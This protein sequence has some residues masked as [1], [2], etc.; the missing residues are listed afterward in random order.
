[1]VVAATIAVYRTLDDQ[2]GFEVNRTIVAEVSHFESE[3]TLKIFQRTQLL[4]RMARRWETRASFD[5]TEWVKDCQQL[6]LENVQ[7]RAI[8]WVGADLA[9]VR[10]EPSSA[11]LTWG[12]LDPQ[13]DG[14]RREQ[15]EY[16]MTRTEATV[17]PSFPL[18]TA[19]RELLIY[20][21]M[22]ANGQKIGG[23]VGVVRVRD[24]LDTILSTAIARGYTVAVYEGPFLDLR[25]GVAGGRR[26][27]GLV[28][29]RPGAR[30][31]AGMEAHDL[32]EPGA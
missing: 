8:A 12:V 16:L 25:S 27:G 29:G 5:S 4:D 24:L 19:R 11:R 32:A 15:L 28:G 31:R 9:T 26:R 1:M 23:L 21:P 13:D 22:F 30:R 17:S 6:M 7:V 2:Q 20:A 14:V 10:F 3:M 18:A